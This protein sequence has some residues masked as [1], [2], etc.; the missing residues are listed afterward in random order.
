MSRFAL[1]RARTSYEASEAVAERARVST[2]Q[3]P[4]RYAEPWFEPFAERV[5]RAL[6]P[7]VTVLDVGSGRSPVVDPSE[8]P[9]GC[10]YVG[11]DVSSAELAQATADAYDEAICADITD[12]APAL[13][14]RFDLIVS[15][16][17]LEHVKP[18]S[19]AIAAM[20]DYLVPEGRL[21]AQLSGGLSAFAVIGR[22]IPH[23]VTRQLMVRVLG[24]APEQ[25]FPA[26][27]DRCRYSSLARMFSGWTEHELLP[28]YKGARYFGFA[29]PVERVYL[30]YES[31]ICR[32]GVAELATH[33]LIEAIR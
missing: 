17:A 30:G 4:A 28:R 2:G 15:W 8:R 7:G 18:L 24:V 14:G 11:L 32:H 19:A 9:S 6:E 22:C 23:A 12:R 27:Y 20:H 10:T 1:G 33:Y 21:V 25:T 3:L 5:S 13:V 16:Q 31:W 26:H 29:R